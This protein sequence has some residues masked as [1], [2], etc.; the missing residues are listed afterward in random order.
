MNAKRKPNASGRN[1][2]ECERD[3]VRVCLRLN[4]DAA[5]QLRELADSLGC[6]LAQATASAV[7]L[8]AK[9]WI[10]GGS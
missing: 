5:A 2:M 10:G 1:L 9:T 7:E 8:A 3:T 6:G 4:A